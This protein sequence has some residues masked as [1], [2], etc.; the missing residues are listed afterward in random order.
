[1]NGLEVNEYI[2]KATEALNDD[3]EHERWW[4]ALY[5]ERGRMQDEYGDMGS[6]L[7]GILFEIW[8]QRI[9]YILD[10]LDDPDMPKY[11]CSPHKPFDEDNPLE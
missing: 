6:N 5:K 10:H 9:G 1:M 3:P 8:N 4:Q 11:H 2:T 7:E